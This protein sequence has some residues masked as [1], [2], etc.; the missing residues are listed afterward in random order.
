VGYGDYFPRTNYARFILICASIFG[1]ILISLIV[2][3]LQNQMTL[4]PFERNAYSFYDRILEKEELKS[5]G[6]ACFSANFKVMSRKMKYKEYLKS[7]K[8]DLDEH[9]T[10]KKELI[11]LTYKKIKHTKAFRNHFQ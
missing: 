10:M 8:F 2:I 9:N 7:N 3:T 4:N 1:S 11:D 6:A 5:K